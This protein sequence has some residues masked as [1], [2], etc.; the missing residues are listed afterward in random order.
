[1]QLE[2]KSGNLILEKYHS[3]QLNYLPILE[4]VKNDL[5]VLKNT[6][7]ADLNAHKMAYEQK[8]LELNEKRGVLSREIYRYGEL[9]K[10]KQRVTEL[11]GL[12]QV[13]FQEMEDAITEFISQKI[14]IN[15]DGLI[16]INDQKE[17]EYQTKFH[18]LSI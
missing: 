8:T 10:E 2:T 11:T 6:H 4:A 12:L 1:M 7:S 18:E 3:I 13:R 15:N 14:K 9:L 5:E 16:D 17:K